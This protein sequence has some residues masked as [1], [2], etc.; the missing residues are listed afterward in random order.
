MGRMTK[1]SGKVIC[2]PE[3][4][5]S[6]IS[7]QLFDYTITFVNSQHLNINSNGGFVLKNRF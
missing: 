5:N 6:S 2:I 1:W 3:S 4:F 7:H